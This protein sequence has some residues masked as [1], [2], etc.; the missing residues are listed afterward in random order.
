MRRNLLLG[1]CSLAFVAAGLVTMLSAADEKKDEK[2]KYTIKQVMEF[3]QKKVHEKFIK[4]EAT[5]EEKEKLLAGYESL[6]K[7][8]PPRGDEANWKKLTEN[9][10]KA[11]KDVDAKKDGAADAF[12]KANACGACHNAHK[13]KS[14]N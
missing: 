4:G 8:K 2:P 13:P 14:T 12:K 11:A 5:K 9:I 10:L 6:T 3:H 1:T 7:Q